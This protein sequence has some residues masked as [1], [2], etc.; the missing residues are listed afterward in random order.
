MKPEKRPAWQ[1]GMKWLKNKMNETL[2]ELLI[3]IL[4]WGIVWQAAGVW[5]VPDK[6]AC[7][8]G[9]WLGVVTAEICAVHMYRSL[10]R[11]LDLSEKDAQKYMMSRSMMRYGLIIVVLLILMVTGIGNPLTG[12]LGV[13]GLKAAAYLQ[14]L[15]HKLMERRR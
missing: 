15:L 2:R 13:M 9:L 11:A 6:A 12:F 8:L 3:G 10:D 1:G 5:F 7:S 14:P 4:L